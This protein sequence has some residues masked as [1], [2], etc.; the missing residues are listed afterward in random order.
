M[1]LKRSGIKS[2]SLAK[3]LTFRHLRSNS[4][5]RQTLDV[6]IFKPHPSE[7]PGTS[8]L[9]VTCEFLF[10]LRKRFFLSILPTVILVFCSIMSSDTMDGENPLKKTCKENRIR[11]D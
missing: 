11:E 3:I 4:N 1:C 2:K 5:Q 8:I 10:D 7:K 6:L 9:L